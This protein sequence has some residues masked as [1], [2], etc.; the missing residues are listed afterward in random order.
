VRMSIV[1]ASR[2]SSSDVATAKRPAA[3]EGA[4]GPRAAAAQAKKLVAL[5]N[6]SNVVAAGGSATGREGRGHG[7]QR[8]TYDPRPIE[9]DRCGG[10]RLSVSSFCFLGSETL[11]FTGVRN[12]SNR[13]GFLDSSWLFLLSWDWIK[14]IFGFLVRGIPVMEMCRK[15]YC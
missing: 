9:R 3:P 14:C 4:A 12:G 2:C 1:A 15:S 6:I 7:R 13:G 11:G 8:G 10:F 5:G